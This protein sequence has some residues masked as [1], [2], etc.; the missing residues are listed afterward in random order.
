MY[1]THAHIQHLTLLTYT[2]QPCHKCVAMGVGLWD[3][4]PPVPPALC[5]GH[6]VFVDSAGA[7][8]GLSSHHFIPVT[9]AWPP[10][11]PRA[12][13]LQGSVLVGSLLP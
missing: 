7:C 10:E 12:G 9:W 5:T 2:T 1:P 3:L 8:L 11:F 6:T 13:R 4:S